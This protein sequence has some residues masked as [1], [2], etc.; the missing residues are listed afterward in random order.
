MPI[1]PGHALGDYEVVELLESST[2]GV[3]YKVRNL[4]LD[5]VEMLRVLPTAVLED[6][7]RVT[8]FLREA[9]VHS[10]INHPNIASFYH[11]A[12]V[13]SE[14]V[15]ATE[16][17]DGTT[18]AQRREEGP[19]PIA[20]ALDYICQVL[21]A[22]SQAHSVGI[23]HRDVTPWNIFLTRGGGVKLTGFRLAKGATDAQLTQPGTVIGSLNYLSPEQI[24]GLAELDGRTDIYS[25]GVVLYEAVTGRRPF[26]RKSQFEVMQAHMSA[27][28]PAPTLVNPEVP[29]ELSEIILKAMAKEPASRFQTAEE[30]RQRLQRIGAQPAAVT[31]G[32]LP[33]ERPVMGHHVG[34][35]SRLAGLLSQVHWRL[36]AFGW[37]TILVA[38]LVFLAVSRRS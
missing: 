13:D 21:S 6:Q 28:A 19:L 1:V 32:S 15:M 38:Y 9:R 31:N 24:R 29:A 26:H 20:E 35:S 5:R 18:L 12:Q 11:A 27:L 3:T 36:V 37:L 22:L 7:E 16:W 23:V 30:F 10:R 33:V 34:G 17:V 14:L 4:L 25:V 2:D 8:R